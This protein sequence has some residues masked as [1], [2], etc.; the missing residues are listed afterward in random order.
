MTRKPSRECAG[1]FKI[2][3]VLEQVKT[4]VVLPVM[5]VG[6]LE[7][8]F[9]IIKICNKML[10]LVYDFILKGRKYMNQ[11]M[12]QLKKSKKSPANHHIICRII[13]LLE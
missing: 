13:L 9:K 10:K 6:I 4:Y 1:L 11:S 3:R 7:F 8:Y 5:K 12:N 2:I